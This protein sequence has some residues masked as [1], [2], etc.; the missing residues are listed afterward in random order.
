MRPLDACAA[1]LA[2]VA[3]AETPALE[4]VPAAGP[5]EPECAVTWL[6][7]TGTPVVDCQDGT[8]LELRPGDT[9]R[10]SVGHDVDFH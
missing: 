10:R 2:L 3:C 6:E 5:P 8:R 9:Y 4:I 1:A 7:P